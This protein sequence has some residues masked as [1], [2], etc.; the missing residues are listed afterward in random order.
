MRVDQHPGIGMVRAPTCLRPGGGAGAGGVSGPEAGEELP[1]EG[2][3]AF[4]TGGGHGGAELERQTLRILDAFAD[5]PH[6][7]NLGHGIGQTTPLEHVG[8]LLSLVR[9]WRA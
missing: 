1:E 2:E 4:A 6:I 7:F 3:E 9:G 8:E 5:R